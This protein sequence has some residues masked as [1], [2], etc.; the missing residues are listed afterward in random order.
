MSAE[1][2]ATKSTDPLYAETCEFVKNTGKARISSV[3]TEF[4]IGYNRA[5]RHLEA[6]E[7]DG[8]VTPMDMRGERQLVTPNIKLSAGE[9]RE[10]K[11]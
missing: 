8:I 4:R 1:T 10:E 3:Q 6:M 5:A 11:L 7:A 2:D 9:R